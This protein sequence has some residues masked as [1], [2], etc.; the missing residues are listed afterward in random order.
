[1]K[2]TFA[3]LTALSLALLTLAGCD[4]PSSSAH[5]TY[6]SNDYGDTTKAER[7]SMHHGDGR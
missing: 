3:L 5:S 2:P 6:D 4:D 1:M 7:A